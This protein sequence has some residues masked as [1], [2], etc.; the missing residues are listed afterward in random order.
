M[1]A[2]TREP[3]VIYVKPSDYQPTKA[4]L[5]EDV[6][7]PDMTAEE[8]AQVVMKTA[9]GSRRAKAV[10]CSGPNAAKKENQ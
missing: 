9:T 2:P 10:G 5:E 4:E 1:T 7:V 8:V 6:G 3:R